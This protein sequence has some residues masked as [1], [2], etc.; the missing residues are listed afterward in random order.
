MKNIELKVRINSLNRM[1]ERLVSSGVDNKGALH[2]IDTYFNSK[3]GRLKL[4]EVNSQ[5][6]EL[7]YYERPD[8]SESK[9]STYQIFSFDEIQAKKIKFVLDS[10]N[11]VLITVEKKRELWMYKNTRIHLDSVINLGEYAELETVVNDMSMQEAQIEHD[12]VVNL[13]GLDQYEKCDVSYS[14][15]LL[16][17]S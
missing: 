5:E 8:T 15:L 7:I 17:K 11:G 13:L 2:Q 9:V 16:K 4:R 6:F 14:D 3:K 1:R 12:E 10:A